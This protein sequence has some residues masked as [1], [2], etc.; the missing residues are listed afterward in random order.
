M[1]IEA[2][3]TTVVSNISIGKEIQMGITATGM[4]RLMANLTNMY[5]D[6]KLAVV[7]EYFANALDSH[8]RAGQTLPVEVSLPSFYN[9]MYVVQDFGTGM[10]LDDIENVYSQYG[11]STKGDTNDEIGAFGLGAKSALAIANQFTLVTIKDGVKATVLIRKSGNGSGIPT[12]S[13]VSAIDTD[14]PNGVTVSIPVDDEYSFNSKAR[15]F[16]R[17]VDPSLVLVDGYAPT[18]VFDNATPIETELDDVEI[19]VEMDRTYGQSYVVMGQVAYALTTANIEESAQRLGIQASY[20]LRNMPVYFRIPIGSVNLT[21][22]REGLLY[23]DKTNA[24]FDS[25]VKAYMD[26]IQK[27]AQEE[28]DATDDRFEVQSVVARWESRLGTKLQWRGEDVPEQIRTAT[29]S[30]TIKRS[31]TT[32]SHGN[33]HSVKLV[34]GYRKIIVT[35][36]PFDKYKRASNYI[37]DYLSMMGIN[38]SLT[39]FFREALDELDTP[40]IT[41]HPDIS[42]EDFNDMIQRVKDYRKAQRAAARAALPKEKQERAAKLEYPVLDIDEDKISLVPYDEIPADSYYIS[43][44]E[45]KDHGSFWTA[46]D[47]KPYGHSNVSAAI[48]LLVGE[49]SSVVFISKGRSL[50]S[51]LTRTRKIEGLKNL[52]TLAPDIQTR[53]NNLLTEEVLRPRGRR[54]IY[55]TNRR[56]AGFDEKWRNQILDEELRELVSEAKPELEEARI[57]AMNLLRAMNV[58]GFKGVDITAPDWMPTSNEKDYGLVYPLIGSMYNSYFDQTQQEHLVMYMNMIYEAQLTLV[59]A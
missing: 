46:F 52:K 29:S 16:F 38:D 49:G 48:A 23:D 34:N 19:Y 43:A 47:G 36:Q 3:A 33:T 5:N 39:F 53:V 2:E 26:T 21:P 15:E 24:M 25:L 12:M 32:S 30:S 37:T 56:I 22:N 9:K 14:E 57:E 8:V 35:G 55:T 40:W 51:F 44:E 13:I 18:S 28:I 1:I 27:T 58:F 10:S 59:D 54:L 6:P 41:E 50:E 42:F 11:E 4:A 7:R 17:F 31:W 45:L 20:E